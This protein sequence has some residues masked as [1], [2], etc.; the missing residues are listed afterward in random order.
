MEVNAYKVAPYTGEMILDTCF[1]RL[2]DTT[3]R[4]DLVVV[5]DNNFDAIQFLADEIGVEGTVWEAW[6]DN[7][8]GEQIF[9]GEQVIGSSQQG[10]WNGN[11]LQQ[12]GTQQVGQVQTGVETKLLNSTVDKRMGDRIV[13]MSMIPYMR[14]LP[15]HVHADNMK[16]EQEFDLS[17]IISMLMLMLNQMISLQ[18]H[19]QIEQILILLHYKTL[20]HKQIATML[21]SL[22]R[23]LDP[24]SDIAYPA[25]AFAIGD[26]VRNNVHTAT[27]VTNAVKSGNTVTITA[28]SVSGIA[29]GHI[30]T[31][32]SIGGAV[33]LNT[34]KY[35]V[36]S[37]NTGAN[38][39][40]IVN[41]DATGTAIST[42]TSY[43]SGGTVTRQQ[44]SGVVTFQGHLNTCN[45]RTTYCNSY[46]KYQEWFCSIRPTY[47]CSR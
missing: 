34:G 5:D 6:Q 39:F 26:V 36:E 47:W 22:E 46:C 8:F 35:R 1:R 7:W 33:E 23:T 45:R 18:L 2:E 21:V 4:P 42:M 19:Q 25:L 41:S 12:T 14:E 10:G 30:V 38:T 29:V 3:R 37:V 43:T 40:T 32:D 20:D 24:D 44:A 31:F 13:D 27:S 17:L 16:P 9:T 15:I 28:S 11:I